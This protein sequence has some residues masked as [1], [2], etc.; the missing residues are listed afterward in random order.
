[1]KLEAK[2]DRIREIE[3][4]IRET[5][6]YTEG[7]F[8]ENRKHPVQG[9]DSTRAF[10]RVYEVYID[11]PQHNMNAHILDGINDAF[12]WFD[13]R[14]VVFK[15]WYD[16]RTEEA[17]M[18]VTDEGLKLAVDTFPCIAKVFGVEMPLIQAA[19]PK[20]SIFS[21]LRAVFSIK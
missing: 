18:R 12:A 14:A 16:Y 11:A 10:T 4:A 1:M 13:S 15:F 6:Q 9:E 19:P 3:D 20:I 8:T 2:I 17:N 5:G 7:L 21:R